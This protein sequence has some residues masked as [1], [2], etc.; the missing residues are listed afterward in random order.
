MRRVGS[1]CY[2]LAPGAA[3]EA[4]LAGDGARTP[5]AAPP[6]WSAGASINGFDAE[7]SGACCASGSGNAAG[8]RSE[9]GSVCSTGLG[10][11]GGTLGK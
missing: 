8:V 6:S 4:A 2:W 7:S 10:G 3:S 1:V 9:D 11:S 5:E